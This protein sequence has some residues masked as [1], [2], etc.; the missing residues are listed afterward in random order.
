MTLLRV[1][2]LILALACTVLAACGGPKMPSG[3][4]SPY[5]DVIFTG[6]EVVTV[7]NGFPIAKGLA[8]K[9]GK[10]IVVGTSDEVLAYRGPNTK[11]VDITGKTVIPGLQDSHIH[12]LTLGYDLKHSADLTFAKSA[13][14]I[15]KA[16]A[17]LKARLN[18]APGSW[19]GGARWDQFKYPQMV[20]RWQL[21]AVTPKNPVRLS[22]VYRG[23]AVNTAV[24]RLMGIDDNQPATWPAWWEKNPE[25]F[26]SED[27]IL[28]AERI[29][30]VNGRERVVQVP[31]GVF[32][33][34]KASQ[35]VTASPPEHTFEEDVESV[36]AGAEEMLSLGVTAIV[37][38]AS[39]MGANMRIYQE[40]YNRGWLPFRIAAVYEGIFFQEAPEVIGA[41]LD[42]IK[43]N[44]LGDRFLKWQGVKFYADGGAG[45]RSS[46]V[47]EPFEDWEAQEGKPY[48]GLPVMQDDAI[49]EK[50]F[51]AAVDRGWDLNTHNTGDRSMRQ[52][53]NLYMK[54]M[55]E[56]HAKRPDADLRWSIIHAY[57]P[58][59]PKT[60]VLPDM[61][62]YKI[63]AS[64]NPVFI[65][66]LGN[67]FAENLGQERVT[68]VQP[69]RS[70]VK[71]GVV[72]ASGSDYAVAHYDPWLGFY[73]LLTRKEQSTGAVLGPQETV[74]IEDALRSFTINGAYL[75]Y[76]DK[77]RGSLEVGKLADLVV[78]DLPS[79][80][81]LEANPELCLTMKDRVL[82]TLVE[83]KVGYRRDGFAF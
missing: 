70:Y 15:V 1:P 12:F 37:D 75:T 38:P 51:R 35:L 6:G 47:S 40:A 2:A 72:M 42:G 45:S 73:A 9:D 52:T 19:I 82:L 22:R 79:I 54:L 28:R 30:T 78:L 17:D 48:F 25:D 74:G 13:D 71:G 10:V 55:D 61:A 41:H 66:Q 63:I 5:A 14:D 50:Q 21:D 59:E 49:R 80:K 26:T 64:P 27:K 46:W 58:I 67:S 33:G 8:I 53:A 60:M 24:F 18:P 31:T 4:W 81:Q 44:R 56:I 68:R 23:V 65:W 29:I 36:K 62:K 43:V 69:F 11:V 34:V 83:G 20:T 39:R 57:M 76:D 3:P 32:L 7:A 16:V 77:V